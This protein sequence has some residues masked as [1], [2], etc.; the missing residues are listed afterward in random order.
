MLAYFKGIVPQTSWS[1]I[2]PTNAKVLR[3]AR[4]ASC[5]VTHIGVFSSLSVGL[6]PR[7]PSASPSCTAYCVTDFHSHHTSFII[8]E[9][10]THIQYSFVPGTRGETRDIVA[11]FANLSASACRFA[12]IRG[13]RTNRLNVAEGIILTESRDARAIA[14]HSYDHTDRHLLLP[15]R[16]FFCL[17][18]P[19][20]WQLVD[21]SITSKSVFIVGT[22]CLKQ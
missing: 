10:H 8:I 2:R 7:A 11:E 9:E 1:F 17:V 20:F 4:D 3:V 18:L 16:Y 13:Y 12:C 21:K 6:S 14:V 19:F 22:R 15:E 5:Y